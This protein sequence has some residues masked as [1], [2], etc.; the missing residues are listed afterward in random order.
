MPAPTL[1]RKGKLLAPGNADPTSDPAENARMQKELDDWVPMEY[2][3]DTLR[4]RLTQ[5]GIENRFLVLKSETASGKSTA[6]PPEIYRAILAGTDKSL[7]CTQPR[8]LTAIE[9]VKQMLPHYPMLRLGQNIGWS[10]G[11]NKYKPKSYGIISATVGTLEQELRI[12][13]DESIMRK[14][15]FIL[16]DETHE[17][18]IPT[19]ITLCMLKRFLIRCA[20]N[21]ACPFVILMSATFEPTRFLEYFGGTL[22]HNFIWCTGANEPIAEMWDWNDGRLVNDFVRA[23]ATLVE[24]IVTEHPDDDP[25]KADVLV[26]LPGAAEFQRIE[27]Y[28]RA[29][30]TRSQKSGAPV[31]AQ[32]QIDSIAIREQAADYRM[33]TA[34]LD[35]QRVVISGVER[36]PARRVVC[37]TNVAE[38]G[39]TLDNLKYV[40]DSGYNREIEFNP[41]WGVRALLTKP[42]P[43]SRIRQRRGRVGRKFAGVF[44]PLYPK[45]IY[46]LL[47]VQQYPQIL[48]DDVTS[49]LL[50]IVAAQLSP[51]VRQYVDS[52]R[53]PSSIT[54]IFSA[55]SDGPNQSAVNSLPGAEMRPS[56]IDLVDPPSPDAIS[57]GF[58]KLYALG[59]IEPAGDGLALTLLGYYASTMGLPAEISRMILAAFTWGA[60][61]VDMVTIAAWIMLDARSADINWLVVYKQGLPGFKIHP[62]KL[63]LLIADDFI[64]GLVLLSAA[65]AQN[66]RPD[67]LR[68]WCEQIGLSHRT[69]LDFI[70]TRDEMI[71]RLL[72]ANIAIFPKSA[73]MRL[74][75]APESELMNA[76]TRVKMC[77]Y[78]G[79]RVN[80]LTRTDANKAANGTGKTVANSM[81]TK[82]GGAR[83]GAG[84]PGSAAPPPILDAYRTTGGIS[85]RAPELFADNE[86]AVMD[87]KRYGLAHGTLP[88]FIVTDTLGLKYDKKRD[89]YD[90]VP[91][92]VCTLDGFVNPDM[93]FNRY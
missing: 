85:V 66:T 37:S 76:V 78:E 43:R 57:Y 59:L 14:Y 40:I 12:M 34:P 33:L 75:D 81:P 47:P 5:T 30:N 69:L 72:G 8:V 35:R 79:Y 48:M 39:L 9:N 50:S 61:P 80:L 25:T 87:K 46:D 63:R 28:L 60:A 1:F 22:L 42:A 56:S 32:L 55:A 64:S 29:I 82:S 93:G 19:D 6:L 70:K 23:A 89:M 51:A 16:I 92:R 7:I 41:E 88:R 4:K 58:A 83:T 52:L 73:P 53:D 21:P 11:Y 45:Y 26:F 49:T 18:D 38:T 24:G 91:G 10:T 13:D 54:Q 15:R 65:S 86:R 44:Y 74:A 62:L 3:I 31:F 90:V 71:E 36:E 67:A 77:I 17:R 20:S 27:S 2:I 84:K 68:T